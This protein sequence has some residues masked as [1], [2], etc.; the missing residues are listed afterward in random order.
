MILSAWQVGLPEPERAPIRLCREGTPLPR[1]EI[2][3]INYIIA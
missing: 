1:D 3:F 2:Y